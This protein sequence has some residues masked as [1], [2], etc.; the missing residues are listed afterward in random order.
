MKSSF[1]STTLHPILSYEAGQ[2]TF[3][4]SSYINF[5]FIDYPM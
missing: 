2:Q 3:D 4:F 5:S 1:K